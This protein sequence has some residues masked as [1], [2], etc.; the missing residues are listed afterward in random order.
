MQNQFHLLGRL[1]LMALIAL[2]LVACSSAATS[3]QT[4]ALNYPI[5]DTEQTYCYNNSLQI[6]CPASGAAFFGQ[7]AQFVGNAPSYND[8]SDGTIT[9]RVTGLMWQKTPGS[10]VTFANALAGA[11]GL[12]LGGYTDWRVPTIKELYSLINFDGTDP[13]T[14]STDTSGLTPFLNTQYFDF[15]YGNPSAGERIID[16]Q[17]W[18]STEYVSTTMN[19]F[20]T[21]FGVN[22]A[23]G[24]IKGYGRNS[25]R[26]EMTQY[27]RYVRGNPN[28]G[29]NNFVANND[30]TITDNATG[31][32]WSQ[33]DSQIGMNWQAA[34]AWVQT[35]NAE[36]YLGHTDW[37]LP[38][39]KELHSIVDYQRSPD[40]T[41]SAAIDP[42]FNVT[43][44]TNELGKTD[45]PFYWTSTTHISSNS[46]GT[47]AVY[48]AFGRAMGYMNGA[49][50]DVHGAGAQRSDPKTG[51]AS[52]YP[53]GRGPQGDA[54]H[55]NNFV[56]VVRGGNVAFTTNTATPS[57]S[58][59]QQ[60]GQGQLPMPGQGPLPPNQN[61]LGNRTGGR[62]TAITGNTISVENPQG[63][64]TIVVNANT[65]FTANG[66]ASPL[67]S[68]TIGKFIEVIG[69]QNNATWIASQI[70][71][72]DRPPM[73]PPQG[74]PPMGGTPPGR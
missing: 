37:R 29:V 64:E 16:A 55:I 28:Y 40:T 34:L 73:Q 51:N 22:F 11:K 54:I 38:N 25:P 58:T 66:Q 53:Q 15:Q 70:T 59:S 45:Y 4:I 57:A 42:L 20:A 68:V 32:M 49:W 36:N 43:A 46:S 62:V 67:A 18:S 61:T 17:Y 23:D 74:Q 26:G 71:I 50:V 31:L 5:V 65:K 72:S 27:V 2:M 39:A 48:L 13:N 69:Q 30:G 9:D 19:G 44:V 10:K 33:A 35:K 24:R 47:T 63:K 8:N 12:N 52:S 1:T 60:S 7:D 14:M 41:N 3:A 6:V 21:T 56:R